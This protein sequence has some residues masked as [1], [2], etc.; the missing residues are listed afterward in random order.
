MISSETF[1]IRAS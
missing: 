1:K